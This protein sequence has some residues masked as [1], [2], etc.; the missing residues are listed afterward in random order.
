MKR[1]MI[2]PTRFETQHYPAAVLFCLVVF[3]LWE[4]SELKGKSCPSSFKPKGD[5]TFNLINGSDVMD[6]R[7]TF[8]GQL[9]FRA[10]VCMQTHTHT[11]S[12]RSPFY[13]KVQV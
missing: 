11:Q 10:H 7:S 6:Q 13:K 5:F 4:P 12:R 3:V 2:R 1:Q 9:R 8:Q